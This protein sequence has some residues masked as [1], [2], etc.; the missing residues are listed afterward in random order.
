MQA[1]YAWLA[2]VRDFPVKPAH[3]SADAFAFGSNLSIW[4]SGMECNV[5][6]AHFEQQSSESESLTACGAAAAFGGN[7]APEV[8]SATGTAQESSP[9]SP[10]A[11]P[12]LE[13]K[14]PGTPV[15][16]PVP[17]C[18]SSQK[19]DRLACLASYITSLGSHGV[20]SPISCNL[21]EHLT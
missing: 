15:L 13:R 11:W 8:D 3:Q 18:A 16:H 9:L 20:G 2:A 19:L 10:A 21:G 5:S 14:R 4:G 1:D 7:S 17:R 12:F 6:P